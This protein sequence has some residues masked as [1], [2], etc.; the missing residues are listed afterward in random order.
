MDINF[1]KQT[2]FK[3]VDFTFDGEIEFFDFDGVK[4]EYDGKIARIGAKSKNTFAR[5]LFLLCMNISEGKTEINIEEKKHFDNLIFFLDCSRNGV[6]RVSAVKKYIDIIASLGF[7]ALMLYTEDTYEIEGRPRFGYLR[8]RYSTEEI[9]EIVAYGEKFDIDVMPCIQTLGHMEQYLK[10]SNSCGPDYTG[11]KIG[12]IRD[13]KDVLLCGEEETYKFIEDAIKACREA[14][15]TKTIHIGMDEAGG[16][17]RG[18]Y[19]AKNGL[20]S[21]FD[22]MQKHLNRVVEICKKYDFKPMIWS[23]MYFRIA[24]GGGYYKYDFTFPEWIKESMPD[25]VE[26]VYWDYYSDDPKRYNNMIKKHYELSDNISFAGAIASS[27]ELL[28][29]FEYSYNNSI[30]G[31]KSCIENNIKTVI[32]TTWGDDGNET[33]AYKL[34]PMIPVYSEYCYKGETCTEEDIH[35]ASEFLTKIKFSDAK[36]MSDFTFIKP[37]PYLAEW[38]AKNGGGTDFLPGKRLFYADVLY[39]MSIRYPS[40]DEVIERYAAYADKMLKLYEKGDKN[41]DDYRYSYLLYKIG[42]KKAELVKNLRKAYK[43][44][45]REYLEKV[46]REILPQIKAWHEEFAHIQH[47]QWLK[48]YKPFGL[49]VLDYRHGG[50]IARLQYAMDTIKK[51]LDGELEEIA[52]LNEDIVINEESHPSMVNVLITPTGMI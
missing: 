37:D 16:V 34:Q 21:S 6:M 33:N 10:W 24:S 47:E 26:I 39:D 5:G 31:L 2:V 25:N 29:R 44:G 50:V 7:D 17:G 49:E 18:R 22:I 12:K 19:L 42:S 27:N 8:G 20:H 4:V 35:K 28:P 13:T 48:V 3:T 52:E 41:K 9:K 46:C 40:C 14:Y 51:Y 38:R 32:L 1:L 43:E 30:T 36:D 15:K 23:D 45:N 11:E